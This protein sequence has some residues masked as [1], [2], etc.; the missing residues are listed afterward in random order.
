MRVEENNEREIIRGT[1]LIIQ[2]LGIRTFGASSILGQATRIPLAVWCSQNKNFTKEKN[3][4]KKMSEIIKEKNDQSSGPTIYRF[5]RRHEFFLI[6]CLLLRYN[7]LVLNLTYWT[8]F[9]MSIY[10]SIW[11]GEKYIHVHIHDVTYSR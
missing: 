10:Q 11:R 9:Y 5:T 1:S 2:W 8:V 3:V 7:V 6:C 4:F